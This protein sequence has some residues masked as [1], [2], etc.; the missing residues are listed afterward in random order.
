DFAGLSRYYQDWINQHSDD[1]DAIGRLAQL[2]THQ[3]RVAEAREWLTKGI[4]RD[5]SRKE[6]RLALIELLVHAAKVP[7][8][9]KQ[10]EELKNRAEALARW[11]RMVEGRAHNAKNLGRLSEVLTSFGYIPEAL[12]ALADAI[13]LDPRDFGLHF[14]RAE[15][16]HQLERFDDALTEIEAAG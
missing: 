12:A 10:Y 6:L 14:H 16:L 3:G 2:L 13:A 1:V 8:A 5:G 11:R 9:I 7:D 15:L 4:E